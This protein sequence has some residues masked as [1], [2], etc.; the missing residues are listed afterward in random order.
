MSASVNGNAVDEYKVPGLFAPDDGATGALIFED[1][2]RI[3]GTSFGADKSIA[4]A[5]LCTGAPLL[6]ARAPSTSL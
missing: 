3:E 2:T 5:F 4:G 6:R 1:G